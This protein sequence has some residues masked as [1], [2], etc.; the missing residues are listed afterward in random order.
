MSVGEVKH[1]KD[2]SEE[3]KKKFEK[4]TEKSDKPKGTDLEHTKRN[5][6]AMMLRPEGNDKATNATMCNKM[7][8]Q[9]K[10]QKKYY[11]KLS[12]ELSKL[13]SDD[14]VKN[15]P[16]TD[17]ANNE[18]KMTDKDKV[19]LQPEKE[20]SEIRLKNVNLTLK[21]KE[22]EE[23]KALD[24]SD[25]LRNIE[26]SEKIHKL[27]NECENKAANKCLAEIEEQI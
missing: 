4:L 1:K 17:L 22:L 14:T 3:D 10:M 16:E 26:L 7:Q 25:V 15:S 6:R 13:E 27:A 24:V 19:M 8:L 11:I 21:P 2:G 23:E 5:N 9:K 20:Q 18:T 12:K